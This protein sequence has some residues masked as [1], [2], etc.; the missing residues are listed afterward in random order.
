MEAV[1]KLATMTLEDQMEFSADFLMKAGHKS[2][3]IQYC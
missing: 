1:K 2:W 3:K